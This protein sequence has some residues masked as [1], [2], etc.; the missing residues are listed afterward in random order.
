[1]NKNIISNLKTSYEYAAEVESKYKGEGTADYYRS[2]HV[3]IPPPKI[4]QPKR[5]KSRLVPRL[6]SAKSGRQF[7]SGLSSTN[8]ILLNKA[9]S[10]G[11]SGSYATRPQTAYQN[12][13]VN[14]Y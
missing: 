7:V 5:P 14:A 12:Q 11:L 2:Q 13:T 6:A 9:P 4:L 1:M 8:K 3:I 10:R